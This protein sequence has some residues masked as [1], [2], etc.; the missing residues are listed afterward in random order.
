MG[1]DEL[2]KKR[3]EDRKRR[4]YEYKNPRANSF[5]I[6]TEGKCTEPLYFQGMQRLIKEKLGG[7]VDVVEAPLI[8]IHG[9]GCA[10]GK[11]IEVTEQLVKDAKIVYQNIWVVFDKDDFEDFDQAIMEAAR[12]GYKAAWSNQSFEYWI[13]LHFNYSDSAL[14]RDEWNKKL[15]E[16]FKQYNLGD[17]KY[18]KNYENIYDM[19]DTYDGVN[20]AIKHA[21]RRM[22]DFNKEKN[23]PSEYDPGTTVYMLAEELKRF[24]DEYGTSV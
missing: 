1:S 22:A 8:E 14:H 23:R 16:I 10:T 2:F 7:G 4:Q 24:I 13:Y 20:L 19:V 9:E 5:L 3:R 18:Q 11:L 21:K 12:K 15:D 17:G 6:V